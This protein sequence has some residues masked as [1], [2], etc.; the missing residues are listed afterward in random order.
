MA[1]V[2][3]R[4]AI[5]AGLLVVAICN[6]VVARAATTTDDRDSLQLTLAE[7]L[8]YDDNLFRLPAGVTPATSNGNT[9]RASLIR[10]D[11]LGFSWNK[12]YSLQQMHIAADVEHH[13]Y[14]NHDFLDF[15]AVNGSLD[16]NWSLTPHVTGVISADRSQTLNSF[17]DYR[18]QAARNVR[19]NQNRVAGVDYEAAGSWHVVA[20][21]SQYSSVNDDNSQ[22]VEDSYRS[23][24]VQAGVKYVFSSSSYLSYS[25][26]GENG[27]YSGQTLQPATLIDS[28]FHQRSHELLAV[29][30][31]SQQTVLSGRLTNSK[32]THPNF[33]Q[34][35]YSGSVGRVG[36]SLKPTGKITVITSVGRDFA[37]YQTAYSNYI[38]T[39]TISISPAW[40]I[41]A[42]TALKAKF[43]RSTRDYLGEPFG[44]VPQ[45]KDN[46]NSSQLEFD[47]DATRGVS[48]GALL[49]HDSRDSTYAGF[50]FTDTTA[51][52][53]LN[54][55]F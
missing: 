38:A 26:H 46:V 40:Q 12:P 30:A 1:D 19:T 35:D 22:P 27:E 28:D 13:H 47:W 15:N 21:A 55:T 23:H 37:V 3:R 20:A 4:A 18:N 14:S 41:S 54:L 34:R 5:F 33:S 53:N 42:K 7:S 8:T 16:W 10:V 24:G 17:T 52:L 39:D 2:E 31:L 36:L 32:R 43:A 49:R 9:A 45:R 25:E 51:I 44:S 29:W 11:N 6:P 48:L 50:Q